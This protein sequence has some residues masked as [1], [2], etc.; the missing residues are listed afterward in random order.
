MIIIKKSFTS[1]RF[2]IR[3]TVLNQQWLSKD[4]LLQFLYFTDDKIKIFKKLYI[5]LKKAESFQ[6]EMSLVYSDIN[7]IS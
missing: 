2:R 7:E 1:K 3:Y 4:H 6:N 5:N